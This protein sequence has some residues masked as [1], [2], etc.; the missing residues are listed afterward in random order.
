VGWNLIGQKATAQSEDRRRWSEA[1]DKPKPNIA[2]PIVSE[3][4]NQS[5]H[6]DHSQRYALSGMLLDIQEQDH[7]WN[8]YRAATDTQHS[9]HS[10][11]HQPYAHPGCYRHRQ[12]TFNS[13][14]AR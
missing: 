13:A 5:S 2:L 6:C 11:C 10:S 1:N 3:T 14:P 9:T 12:T 7:A 8:Q 4:S